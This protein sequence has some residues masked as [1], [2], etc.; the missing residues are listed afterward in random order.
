M[1]VLFLPSTKA[2]DDTKAAITKLIIESGCTLV[3]WYKGIQESEFDMMFGYTDEDNDED[4]QEFLID[5]DYEYFEKEV[6]LDFE[7]DDNHLDIVAGRGMYDNFIKMNRPLYICSYF[8]IEPSND[9]S[10]YQVVGMLIDE[11]KL[12]NA[13][14]FINYAEFSPHPHIFNMKRILNDNKHNSVSTFLNDTPVPRFPNSLLINNPIQRRRL[15]RW[16]K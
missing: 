1:R 15:L 8:D 13:A 12:L 10:N 6:K 9:G 11:A 3:S 2:N 7:W 14:D 5:F 4:Y 16:K